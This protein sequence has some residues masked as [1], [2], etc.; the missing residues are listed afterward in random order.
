LDKLYFVVGFIYCWNGLV[1]IYLGFLYPDYKLLKIKS[2][3]VHFQGKAFNPGHLLADV[4]GG[5]PDKGT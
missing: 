2:V 4:G 1:T 5:P 3:V